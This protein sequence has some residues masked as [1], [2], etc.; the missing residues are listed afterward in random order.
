MAFTFV[1]FPQILSHGIMSQ[2]ETQQVS[3][4]YFLNTVISAYLPFKVFHFSI[5]LIQ[6][7]WIDV[8]WQKDI[9]CGNNNKDF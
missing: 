2:T 3:T 4:D 8:F 1:T 7:S 6:L 5:S 9:I